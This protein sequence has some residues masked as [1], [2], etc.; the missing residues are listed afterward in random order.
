MLSLKNF[1][2]SFLYLF[3]DCTEESKRSLLKK[4][5]RYSYWQ[6]QIFYFI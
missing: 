6:W 2:F 3:Y 1:F 4:L 5:L